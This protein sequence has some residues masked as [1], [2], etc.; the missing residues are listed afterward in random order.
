MKTIIIAMIM[1]MSL[2]GAKTLKKDTSPRDTDNIVFDQASVQGKYSNLLHVL[3]APEDKTEYGIFCDWGYW[4]G[5]EYEHHANLTPGFWVYVYPNWYI[6]EKLSV[7]ETIVPGAS[8]YG[9]YT[10]LMHVL[11]VSEDVKIY[12]A[13][14]D[15]GFSEEYSYAGY[16]NLTP[17]YWVYLEPNWYVWGDLTHNQ[18]G[19]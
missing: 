19:T 7:E 12:S 11:H 8:A 2:T 9:K 16:D 15:W 18:G 1:T 6:W 3:R 4:Y 17:G 13:F 5:D 14:Y 10:L